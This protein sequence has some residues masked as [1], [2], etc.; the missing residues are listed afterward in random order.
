[1]G[2]ENGFGALNLIRI[3]QNSGGVFTDV[4]A[5]LP[6]NSE[7]EVKWV[8]YDGDGDLD[9]SVN[10]SGSTNDPT[11]TLYNNNGGIFTE[12]GIPLDNI[13]Y[14]TINWIDFDGDGDLDLFQ[15][16]SDDYGSTFR[17]SLWENTVSPPTIYNATN[18][19]NAGFTPNL[20]APPGAVD[21]IVDVST[22]PAFGSFLPSGQDI[23]I[24]ISGGLDIGVSL[25]PGT[26]YFYRAKTD[27]GGGTESTYY[28]SNGFMVGQGNALPFTVDDYVEMFDNPL[29][30]PAGAFTIEFWFSTTA[31]GNRVFIEKGNTDAEYSVQQ[32]AGDQ[33]AL[34]VNLGSMQTN[35]SYNDGNWHHVAVVYRGVGDG[36]IYVDG[37]DDTDTGSNTLGI[38]AYAF[39]RLNIGDRRFGGTFNIEG[40][41]DEVRIWDDE[42]TLTEINDFCYAKLTGAETGLLVYYRF[43]ETTGLVLPDLSGNGLNGDLNNMAGTEWVTS[44]SGQKPFVTT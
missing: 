36:T 2:A 19:T 37:I 30:E 41:I 24:G 8:D 1:A 26:Q 18:V 44:Y 25:T 29:L 42:R 5:G 27:F 35:G 31:S 43:D 21:L 3:Y 23:S 39:G 28:V 11:T 12:S 13:M 7:G 20:V 40:S 6:D 17:A 14:G 32:T 33:I 34:V 38:P 9:I 22:D 10:G 15:T 16:G 4:N